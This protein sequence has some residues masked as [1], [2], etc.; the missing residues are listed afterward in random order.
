MQA[1]THY[2]TC[3]ACGSQ[4][5]LPAGVL[6]KHGYTT[7]WGFFE[8]TCRGSGE[9]PF[10][11]D[12]SLIEKFIGYAQTRLASNQEFLAGLKA[13]PTEPKGWV[14]IYRTAKNRYELSGYNWHLVEFAMRQEQFES[15]PSAYYLNPDT[16]KWENCYRH[17]LYIDA[18]D[19]LDVAAAANLKR[20]PGVEA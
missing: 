18:K 19:I 1:A 9:R 6:A 12:Y 16:N 20:V 2:G 8:G 7:K 4:Q 5:K 13:R 17:G 15:R 14:H 3:Q 11:K 10:E